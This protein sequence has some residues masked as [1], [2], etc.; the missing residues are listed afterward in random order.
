[1]TC[2]VASV[3]LVLKKKDDDDGD[4][5]DDDDDKW[6]VNLRSFA[7]YLIQLT[8]DDIGSVELVLR[9]YSVTFKC[10]HRLDFSP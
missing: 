3:K 7:N 5:D 10:R 4:D 2:T 9:L 8:D 1:M 6:N